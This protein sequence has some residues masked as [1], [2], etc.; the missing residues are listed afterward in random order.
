MVPSK[1]FNFGT[2][3][4]T[5]DVA[6]IDEPTYGFILRMVFSYINKIYA[7]DLDAEE[8]FS[9]I[10]G[11]TT[12]S[13]IVPYSTNL[14]VDQVVVSGAEESVITAVT[15]NELLTETTITVSP[16]FTIAPTSILV[17]LTLVPFDLQYAIYQHAKFLFESQKKN[18]SIIDSVTDATGNK[19]TYKSKPSTMITSVYSEYSP[20][21]VAF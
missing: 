18:T 11:T 16:A 14:L 5:M 4:S 10:T 7:I 8:T 15:S 2:F 19:A 6:D 3:K 20:N 9:T 1:M 13:I 12:S 21:A 17:K